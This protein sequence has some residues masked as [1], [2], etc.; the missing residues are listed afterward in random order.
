MTFVSPEKPIDFNRNECHLKVFYIKVPALTRS[1]WIGKLQKE[2]FKN[3]FPGQREVSGVVLVSLLLTLNIF[4]TLFWCS[5]VNF[6]QV[7]ADCKKREKAYIYSCL[8]RNI[9]VFVNSIF[10]IIVQDSCYQPMKL[11]NSDL[12][13]KL[14]PTGACGEHGRCISTSFKDFYCECNNGWKGEHCQIST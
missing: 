10:S 12:F 14:I 8:G 7:N 2:F 4:H 13:T 6:E 5:V 1:E 9:L 11:L 3:D